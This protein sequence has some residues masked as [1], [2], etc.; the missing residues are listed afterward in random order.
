M[1]VVVVLALAPFLFAATR[2]INVAAT[3]CVFALL[4]ASYDLLL[5][6]AGIVLFAHTMFYGIGSYGVAIAL[7]GM[8]ASWLAIFVGLL[9]G[10][11]IAGVLASPSACSRCACRRSSSP[12]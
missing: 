2:P 3:V 9:A 8:G 1:L 6:Y 11:A 5:G 12:W 10:L 7:Y 4:V